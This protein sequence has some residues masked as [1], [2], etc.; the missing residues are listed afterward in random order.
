ML[1]KQGWRFL[2][3]PKSLASCVYKARYFPNSTFIDA[4]LGNCPSFCWRSIM[5]SHDLICTGVRRRIGNG[6]NTMVMGDPWL[7]GDSSPMVQTIMPPH[8]SVT[9]VAGLIDPTTQSWDIP[10]LHEI[11]DSTDIDHIVRLL[12]SPTSF[13]KYLD[14]ALAL[15]DFD[16]II[17]M[18]AVLWSLWNAHND[19]I[20]S[21]GGWAVEGLRRQ[22]EAR[23]VV[24]KENCCPTTASH[25]HSQMDEGIPLPVLHASLAP[26]SHVGGITSADWL[27]EVFRMLKGDELES[28]TTNLYGIWTA[29]NNAL[30]DFSLP[31][32]NKTVAAA[33]SVVNAWCGIY[34]VRTRQEGRTLPVHAQESMAGVTGWQCAFDTGFSPNSGKATYGVVLFYVSGEFIAATNGLLSHLI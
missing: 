8:L 30:W 1:G 20:W 21:N 19:T 16:Q 27:E 28:L 18:A 4:S 3:K 34:G 25:D 2:T 22:V 10:L 5:A 31:L 26:I 7:P 15:S 24:W 11:F 13:G 17:H 14:N 32:P 6:A 9:T 29:R 23:R 12:V 33:S